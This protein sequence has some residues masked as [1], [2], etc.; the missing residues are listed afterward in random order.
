MKLSSLAIAALF[1]LFALGAFATEER[2]GPHELSG[3]LR[4]STPSYSDAM[5]L[6]QDLTE[7]G[8]QV[9]CVLES[10][11]NGMFSSDQL[12][13]RSSAALFRTDHGDFEAL[14][15]PRPFTFDSAEVHEKRDGSRYI[16]SFTGDPQ[17]RTSPDS[18]RRMYFVKRHHKMFIVTDATLAATLADLL[19]R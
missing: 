3:S 17:S 1:G 11:M 10:K 5:I 9:E 2:C 12:G 7:D 14:F 19:M 4:L 13:Y 18:P 16:Y 15:L 8:F 6:K